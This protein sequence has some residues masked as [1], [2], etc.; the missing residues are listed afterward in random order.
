MSSLTV[1]LPKCYLVQESDYPLVTLLNQSAAVIS[2]NRIL[3]INNNDYQVQ[4][5]NNLRWTFVVNR[6]TGAAFAGGPKFIPDLAVTPT[7]QIF[8]AHMAEV[9]GTASTLRRYLW[10]WD[11]VAA[12]GV[13]ALGNFARQPWAVLYDGRDRQGATQPWTI[14]QDE[15]LVIRA[16]EQNAATDRTFPVDVALELAVN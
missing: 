8:A 1:H 3:L 11:G 15:A 12:A 13:W 9:N 14:R 10:G 2:V 7:T 6:Y 16:S 4:G 5:A